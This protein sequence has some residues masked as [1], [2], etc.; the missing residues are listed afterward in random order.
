[1]HC[2]VLIKIHM[3]Q[4]FDTKFFQTKNVQ[5]DIISYLWLTKPEGY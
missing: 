3:R 2:K 4:H 1:M 5:P